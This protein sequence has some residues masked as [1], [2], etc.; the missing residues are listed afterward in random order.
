LPLENCLHFFCQNHAIEFE[1]NYYCLNEE[2]WN[3]C[4]L[5]SKW[6]DHRSHMML[7]TLHSI[8]KK[9]EAVLSIAKSAGVFYR[10]SLL[11][12]RSLKR[13]KRT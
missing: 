2:N 9:A 10:I 4:D 11:H 3:F 7:H 6:Q 12:F 5:Y 8:V 13:W 1:V